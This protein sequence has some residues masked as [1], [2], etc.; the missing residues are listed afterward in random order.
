MLLEQVLAWRGPSYLG[1]NAGG[2]WC[3]GWEIYAYRLL[4]FQPAAS[5]YTERHVGPASRTVA[6]RHGE[7][8]D[9]IQQSGAVGIALLWWRSAWQVWILW[10]RNGAP[11]RSFETSGTDHYR[12]Q[13][14]TPAA[15]PPWEPQ[16]LQMWGV[17]LNLRV[18]DVQ[19]IAVSSLEQSVSQS[20]R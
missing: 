16:I 12:T 19:R 4:I 2:C 7:H 13:R 1:D 10:C 18:L 8:F 5:M 9:G 17:K 3:W 6:F 15:A 14:H 11:L 20:V